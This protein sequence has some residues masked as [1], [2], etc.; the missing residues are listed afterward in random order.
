[1]PEPPN[2]PMARPSPPAILVT[3]S[4][5]SGTTWVGRMLS[6]AATVAYLHE[7]F[8][9]REGP[10]ILDADIDRWFAYAPDLDEERLRRAYD[11]LLQL[12]YPLAAGLRDVSRPRHL[13]R[14]LRDG[15]RFLLHRIFADRI[16]VKD[17]ISALS[18]AWI[19]DRFDIQVV[20]LVRHPAAFAHSLTRRRWDFPFNDLLAQPHL[21]QDHLEPFRSDL[22]RFSREPQPIVEQAALLWSVLYHVLSRHIDRHPGWIVVRHEDLAIDPVAGF[23]SLHRKL[24]LVFSDASRQTVVA[25]S[26]P[27]NPVDAREEPQEIR[28][29]SHR[30]VGRWREEMDP[31]AIAVIRDRTGK[32]AFQWYGDESWG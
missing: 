4:H 16:L 19:A 25:H 9:P 18:S 14:A 1:M 6:A 12:R 28:R 26:H 10:A 22:E 20:V 30:V 15:G 23:S 32:L 8:H 13:G 7:P 17:P 24:G 2:P 3:G 21:M 31:E 11:R 29:E 5:R 27:E